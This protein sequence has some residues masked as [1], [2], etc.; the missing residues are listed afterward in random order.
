MNFL[1][2]WGEQENRV[3]CFVKCCGL[4]AA[5]VLAPGSILASPEGMKDEMDLMGIILNPSRLAL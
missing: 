1:V 3:R 4:R 5:E 2:I